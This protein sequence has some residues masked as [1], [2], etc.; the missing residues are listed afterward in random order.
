MITC[1]MYMWATPIT[2]HL[3]TDISP[4]HE[5]AGLLEGNYLILG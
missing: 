3:I 4:T 5:N 1:T 2:V